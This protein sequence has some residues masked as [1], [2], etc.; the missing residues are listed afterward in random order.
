[1]NPGQLNKKLDIYTVT[2]DDSTG[3][4]EQVEA[5]FSTV[6]GSVEMINGFI[7]TD[8]ENNANRRRLSFTI[9]YRTLPERLIV[10]FQGGSYLIDEIKDDFN[11]RFI[12]LSG[13][14]S[15]GS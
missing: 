8:N 9:R 5:L 7:S 6:W 13:A 1:M 11:K 2:F 12:T 3:Y 14:L 4:S 10:K 15:N